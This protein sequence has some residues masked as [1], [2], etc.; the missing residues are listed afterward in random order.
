MLFDTTQVQYGIL[1]SQILNPNSENKRNL[2]LLL[3][4]SSENIQIF[5]LVGYLLGTMLRSTVWIK[6]M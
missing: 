1:K 6:I 5:E 3:R 4:R 2:E